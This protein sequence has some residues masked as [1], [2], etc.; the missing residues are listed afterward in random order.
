MWPP[1]E[2]LGS[3]RGGRARQRLVCIFHGTF[4]FLVIEAQREKGG[5]KEF[6]KS[7]LLEEDSSV[8]YIRYPLFTYFIMSEGAFDVSLV[9]Y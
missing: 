2:D 4:R 5:K 7:C 1:Q 6:A 3:V 9:M 8:Q